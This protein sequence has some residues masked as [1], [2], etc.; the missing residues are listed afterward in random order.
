MDLALNNLQRL[1]CHKTET[2][3]QQ[4]QFFNFLMVGKN[5]MCKKIVCMCFY[6]SIL[7]GQSKSSK[8]HPDGRALWERQR[9]WLIDQ[10]ILMAY[11]P[12]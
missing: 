1:I 7:E 6:W 3:N 11:Q 4:I 5:K 10:L 12:I 2:S 8:P 9:D